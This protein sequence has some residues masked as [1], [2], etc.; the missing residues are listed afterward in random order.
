[1]ADTPRTRPRLGFLGTGWIGRHRMQRILASDIAEVAALADTNEECLAQAS[2][3]AP[4]AQRCRSLEDLLALELDGLVIATPSAQ[5]AEQSVRALEHGLAVFGQKPLGRN[6]TEVRGVV[7]AARRADRLL[8][9]DLSY[10]HVAGM[11]EIRRRIRAGEL[12][13]PFGG[14]LVFH[15]AYGPD[16]PWFY[17]RQLAGGGCLMD[18]GVHLVDLALWLFDFPAVE[19]VSGRCFAGGALLPPQPQ[20]VEDFVLARLDLANGMSL[21]LACS[22]NLSAGQDADIQASFYGTQGGACL[23]NVNGSFFDF[24]AEWY[25]GTQ[26][27]QLAG[28]PDD[29]GGRAAVAW[30]GAVA[31]G[32]GFDPATDEL[33]RV[34]EV[35]DAIYDPAHADSRPALARAAGS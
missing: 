1:M 10:R 9:V 4:Q 6:A 5:H 25:R 7:A 29:W 24:V 22:W 31:A 14:R 27:E 21:E 11:A 17:D 18:L 8:G 23:R 28:P 34:A 16:K 2:A 30:A 35:L 20:A 26:R 19:G 12:G 15:N 3:D 32:K 33:V 13:R